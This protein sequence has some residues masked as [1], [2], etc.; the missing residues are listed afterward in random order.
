[1][2]PTL[3][4]LG[5]P[6]RTR[7]YAGTGVA[8]PVCESEFRAFAPYHGRAG[9]RCPSCLSLERH[10]LLWLYLSRE[11]GLLADRL[12][13]LHFAPEPPIQ[14]RL[15][16]QPNVE[17][18]SADLNPGWPA[19]LVADITDLPFEDEA[20]DVV[21]CNHVLEHV[22]DDAAAIS[23]T[24]RVLRPGGHAF[25]LHPLDESRQTT[26]E[27][28]GVTSGRERRRLYGQRDHVRI[29][30]S[31][32]YSRLA[33]GGFEVEP[34]RYVEALPD[35]EQKRYGTRDEEIAVGTKPG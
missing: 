1:M 32:F 5:R 26:L 19:M 18:V 23:E 17:Y 29:Y 24:F 20:F 11:T 7:R 35:E 8:C 4:R 34:V 15:R 25:M 30:G 2:A 28:P 13:V 14:D 33:G 10:R 16:S 21:I 6:W 3:H 9:A 27:D 22:E 12:S 31:D